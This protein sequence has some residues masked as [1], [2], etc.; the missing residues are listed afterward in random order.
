MEGELAASFKHHV[1]C[2][3]GKWASS[4]VATLHCEEVTYRKVRTSILALG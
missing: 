2:Q 1:V 3:L 4:A